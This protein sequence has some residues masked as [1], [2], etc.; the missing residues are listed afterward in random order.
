[1]KTVTILR[2]KQTR[3]EEKA[4]QVVNLSHST[5]HLETYK[6]QCTKG[7]GK[8]I[9]SMAQYTPEDLLIASLFLC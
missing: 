9:I 1:M 8:K 2:K 5:V 7:G 4:R 6:L 3:N